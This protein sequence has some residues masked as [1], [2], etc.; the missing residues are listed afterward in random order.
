MFITRMPSSATPRRTSIEAMRSRRSTGPGG[1]G[2][3][4]VRSGAMSA[5]MLPPASYAR[6]HHGRWRRSICASCRAVLHSLE[7]LSPRGP[8]AMMVIRTARAVV[9]SL[10]AAAAAYA[11][12]AGGS[13][14]ADASAE[15]EAIKRLTWRSIG[16]ANQAG[17]ISV[18]VGIPGDPY[19]FFVSGANGG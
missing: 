4:S 18:I 12:F 13:L 5:D 14:R 3:T 6:R 7:I 16:P 15:L 1:A 8:D 10:L 17:R 11:T 9:L 2:A 19:T